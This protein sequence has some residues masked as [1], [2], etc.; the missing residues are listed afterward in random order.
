MLFTGLFSSCAKKDQEIRIGAISCLTGSNASYGGSN[1]LGYEFAAQEWNARGGVL[2]KRIR[3][4][5]ADDKGD[6][7]EGAAVFTRLIEQDKVV[8]ILGG[9]QSRV[10]LAG[11]PIAQAAQ[12]PMVTPTATD[13]KVTAIGNFIFRACY[14]NP[15]QGGAAARFAF[16]GLKARKAGCLFE[17]DSSYSKGLAESFSAKF[18]QLG[19]WLA[20]P[21]SHP[22]GAEDFH[23]P[24]QRLIQAK[25]EL[26]YVPDYYVD[27]A[28]I[29]RQARLLG[30]K[31]ALLGADGWDSPKLVQ[32]AGA[33]LE[34]AFFTCHFSKDDPR[35]E[36]QSFVHRFRAKYG[37][38]PD[39]LAVQA[40]DAA[41]ILLEA[42]RRAGT[43]DGPALRKAL[44]ATDLRG[45]SGPIR[46]DAQRN[47]V[48]SAT[49]LE[50]KDRKQAYRTTVAS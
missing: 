25:V 13:P 50:L 18:K 30:F 12:I 23:L 15:F 33:A 28:T 41:S 38:D 22:S 29:A 31:G 10:A 9:T 43:T 11:A 40:Y 17:S 27:A 39:S 47:P 24:L 42:I 14:T 37:D 5:V 34:P 48:K 44:E 16:E 32:L 4:V 8:G 49:I 1:H 35:P 19:G 36:T 3:L 46:F 20:P 21:E 6:P 45:V 2:G 26:L 7:L